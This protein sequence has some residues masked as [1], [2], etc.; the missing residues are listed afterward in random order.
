MEQKVGPTSAADQESGWLYRQTT[1]P[2]PLGAK[3]TYIGDSPFLLQLVICV[4]NEQ[5]FDRLVSPT[6]CVK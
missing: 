6:V 1:Y 3:L 4:S 2:R 5:S